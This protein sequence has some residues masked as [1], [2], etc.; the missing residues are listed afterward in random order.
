M[1]GGSGAGLYAEEGDHKHFLRGISIISPT[2][3]KL[4]A[5][6][7]K[8]INSSLEQRAAGMLYLCEPSWKFVSLS[9]RSQY[10]FP[11]DF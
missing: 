3:I 6:T 2:N 9:T 10:N 7:D 4:S 8:A 11:L 5:V 1:G